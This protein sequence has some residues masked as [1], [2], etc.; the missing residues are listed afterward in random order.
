VKVE[1]IE[2][3]VFKTSFEVRLASEEDVKIY[4]ET[5]ARKINLLL[6]KYNIRNAKGMLEQVSANEM[7]A[8][9][10][11]NG[12]FQSTPLKS[13]FF[14]Q[15][16]QF[17]PM[18]IIQV[19][20][21]IISDAPA[22]IKAIFFNTFI[23]LLTKKG[24]DKALSAYFE[25]HYNFP[26]DG[27]I[28]LEDLKDFSVGFGVYRATFQLRTPRRDRVI[29]FLK[30]PYNTRA[31]NELLYLHLQK[32]LLPTACYAKIPCILSDKENNE[33]LLLSP[34]IPGITSDTALSLL[35]RAYRETTNDS[36]KITLKIS[37]EMIIEAFI[38]HAALG[39]L[40]GRNDRHLMNSM[41]ASV[42]LMANHKTIH[43]KI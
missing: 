41:I 8:L 26:L 20:R 31:Y 40:L 29:V 5:A 34:L 24:W 30:K 17:V 2:M 7:R 19:F 43:W 36:H 18:E 32:D 38:S 15:K 10:S 33:E 25:K 28:I 22:N 11:L 4:Y 37:L 39:D 1:E 13:I 23:S 42:L 27:I 14:D 35:T 16:Q 6:E 3:A 9:L 21:N 12:F